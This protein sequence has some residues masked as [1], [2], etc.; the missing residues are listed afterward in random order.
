M[1]RKNERAGYLLNILRR[2]GQISVTEAAEMLG[3]SGATVRRLF[4]SMEQ[5]GLAMRSHGMLRPVPA[6]SRYSFEASAH[7]YSREKQSVGRMAAMFVEDGDTIYLDCGTTV[8]QMTLALAQRIAAGEFHSLNIVTNSIANV[9]AINPTAG[10]RLILVG[11]EYDSARRDF[12]G[13]LTER[14]LAPFHFNRCFLGC[15]G[16]TRRDGFS[17]KNANISSLNTCVL[18]RSDAAYVLC[19]SSKL[20]RCSMVSYARLNQVHALV[21]DAEPSPELRSALQSAQVH[22]NLCGTEP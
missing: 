4:V 11:G 17:S 8:F 16:V 3:V 5:E 22:I 10:C 13:A 12:S 2:T 1:I 9:Q 7:V 20:D 15:D 14:F 6:G 19:D 18:E 21:T